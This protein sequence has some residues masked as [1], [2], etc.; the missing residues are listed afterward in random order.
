MIIT[1]VA[2]MVWMTFNT[3]NTITDTDYNDKYRYINKNSFNNN[4]VGNGI[5]TKK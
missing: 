3:D 2:I 1:M 4:D 5:D